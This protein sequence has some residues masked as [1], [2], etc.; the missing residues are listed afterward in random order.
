MRERAT[1]AEEWL[2]KKRRSEADEANKRELNDAD[3]G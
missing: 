2:K 1:G 3:S